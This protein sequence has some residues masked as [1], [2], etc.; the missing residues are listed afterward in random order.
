[1]RTIS[2]F[3]LSLALVAIAYF[4]SIRGNTSQVTAPEKIPVVERERLTYTLLGAVNG[5]FVYAVDDSQGS[6]TYLTT[7]VQRANSAVAKDTSVEFLARCAGVSDVWKISDPTS[8]GVSR[9]YFNTPIDS[10]FNGLSSNKV[11]L[12]APAT[13][14]IHDSYGNAVT[15]VYCIN[16][17]ISTA[18]QY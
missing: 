4:L 9:Y 2:I 18:Q 1:M 6:K 13:L 14:Y 11:E 17:R 8:G 15:D 3:A 7:T 5:V 16:G 12:I 10:K